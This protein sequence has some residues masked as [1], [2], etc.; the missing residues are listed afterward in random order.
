MSAA[1]TTDDG[2]IIASRPASWIAGIAIDRPAKRNA[3]SPAMLDAL[4]SEFTKANRDSDVRVLL[5]HASGDHFTGGLDLGAMT[6]AGR[7]GEL[8]FPG[9]E[10]DPV[11]LFAPRVSKPVVIAVEGV[12][13]TLGVE[14]ILAADITVCSTTARFGQVEVQRSVMAYAG[15]TIRMVERFG[16]GNAMR[17]LLCGDLFDADEALRLGLVQQVVAA[18]EAYSTALNLAQTIAAAAPLAV[19]ATIANAALS[20][21]EGQAAAIADLL[22]RARFLAATEDAVE[23]V[24]AFREKRPPI[25][26]GR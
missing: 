3:F 21:R 6:D 1:V 11:G 9:A 14:L 18:G 4:A 20:L 19:Q 24:T 26:S 5:L 23:G 25:Y 12:C 2:R 16:W 17:Y 7:I 15:A 8:L 22:P 10:T 13:L